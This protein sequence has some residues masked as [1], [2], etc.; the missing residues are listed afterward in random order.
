[1]VTHVGRHASQRDRD[2]WT[3]MTQFALQA[4]A[5]AQVPVTA[6]VTSIAGRA[7]TLGN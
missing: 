2:A 6:E 3:R 4:Q 7:T 5:C 1:M